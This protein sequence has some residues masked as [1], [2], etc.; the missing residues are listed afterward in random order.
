MRGKKFAPEVTAEAVRQW[1]VLAHAVCRATGVDIGER[2]RAVRV[3]WPR[4]IA[5]REMLRSGYTCTVVSDVTGYT[6]STV[7]HGARAVDDVVASPRQWA[8]GMEVYKR[9]KDK[10]DEIFQ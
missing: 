3:S 7:L 5:F 8:D 10:Y 4:F 9:I 2:T 1:A 6:R